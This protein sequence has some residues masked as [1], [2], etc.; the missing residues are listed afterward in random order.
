MSM[1]FGKTK[2]T[3]G[4]LKLTKCGVATLIFGDIRSHQYLK[5]QPEYGILLRR[6]HFAAKERPTGDALASSEC[7]CVSSY[8][9]L[10]VCHALDLEQRFNHSNSDITTILMRISAFFRG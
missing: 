4:L 2:G 6:R 7:M 5:K 10:F 9:C 3:E 1:K 8:F